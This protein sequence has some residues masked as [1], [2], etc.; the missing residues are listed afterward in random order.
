MRRVLIVA[1][2]VDLAAVMIC[3]KQGPL[4]W[5]GGELDVVQVASFVPHQHGI[6]SLPGLTHAPGITLPGCVG[7]TR[8]AYN[9]SQL[10]RSFRSTMTS[11]PAFSGLQL[12]QPSG[13]VE[14]RVGTLG[15]APK[16]HS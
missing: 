11:Q 12:P 14:Q 8:H 13:S 6:G 15:G 7:D 5:V 10:A 2:S 1:A 16:L 4:A 9:A 3:C